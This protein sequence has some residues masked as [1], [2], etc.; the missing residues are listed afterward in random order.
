FASQEIPLFATLLIEVDRREACLFTT[1]AR[2]RRE[3][4]SPIQ[5]HLSLCRTFMRSHCQTTFSRRTRR[6]RRQ[7]LLHFSKG[8][9]PTRRATSFL[10]TSS[11]T[12]SCAST[13]AP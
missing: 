1:S 3:E 13:L 2:K 12:A 4:A 6:S 5:E 10:P 8:L 11:I 9:Q 7:R